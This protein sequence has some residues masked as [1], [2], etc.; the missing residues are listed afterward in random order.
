VRIRLR[1]L[2]IKRWELPANQ[3]TAVADLTE[4]QTGE[5]VLPADDPTLTFHWP[6][7]LTR[8]E[9]QLAGKSKSSG[10][11][12]TLVFSMLTDGFSPQL[13]KAGVT[14]RA[15]RLVLDQTSF[16]IRVL[17]KNA[18]VGSP[19]WITFFQLH[20]GRF[21]VGLSTGT[22]DDDWA[23]RVEIN[24]SVPTARL[25]S[26]RALQDA[27]I[28]T[29]GM[30][31]P[32]F[33][34]VLEGDHLERLIDAVRPAQVEHLWAEP[35]NDRQNWRLVANCLEVS[36]VDETLFKAAYEDGTVQAWSCYATELYQRLIR[37]AN[38]EGWAHKLRYLLYESDI[39]SVDAP[40]FEGLGG[41][42]LQ[43]KP[44]VDGRSK[45]PGLAIYQTGSTKQLESETAA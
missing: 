18:I 24:T 5:R 23:K 9:E 37:K 20:S 17:T 11:G 3:P 31:C 36:S 21:V 15:L 14:E 2:L 4:E 30:L 40:A 12:E 39:T 7:V 42:L 38:A 1:L 10:S 35:Y 28:P 43:A 45:N 6:D 44:G 27:G 8:L 26:H 41:V 19:K 25:R 32:L 16:R 22:L 29:Y 34:H 33:P 13:V